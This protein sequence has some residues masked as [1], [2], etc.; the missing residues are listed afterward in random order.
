MLRQVPSKRIFLI[1][2]YKLSGSLTIIYCVIYSHESS[3]CKVIY[4][5]FSISYNLMCSTYLL[6]C[7]NAQTKPIILLYSYCKRLTMYFIKIGSAYIMSTVNQH[8]N[9]MYICLLNLPFQDYTKLFTAFNYNY[10]LYNLT[11]INKML[12][13]VCL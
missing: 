12:L 3:L 13:L 7:F 4:C 9:Y 2:D 5:A 8:S 1:F 6:V 11:N 10:S